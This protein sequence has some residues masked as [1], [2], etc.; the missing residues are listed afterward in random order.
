M[1][2]HAYVRHPDRFFKLSARKCMNIGYK[3]KARPYYNSGSDPQ[4]REASV[5][6]C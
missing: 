2:A 3:Q 5:K 6:V 4:V 1:L